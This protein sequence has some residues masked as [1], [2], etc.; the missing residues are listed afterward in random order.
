MCAHNLGF[1]ILYFLVEIRRISSM[2]TVEAIKTLV[3]AFALSRLDH[4]NSLLSGRPRYLLG[5]LQK[6]QKSAVKSA[7]K[8]GKGDHVQPLQQAFQ[9]LPVQARTDYTQPVNCLSQLLSDSF[10][11]Y[12]SDLLSVYTP[13]RKLRSSADTR[14]LRIP[15]LE[16]KHSTNA[17]SPTVLLSNGIRSVL[18]SVTFSPLMSSKLL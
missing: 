1:M 12:F 7:F 2:L 16:Q 15:V 18:R 14:M 9:W 13:S 4:C 8:A 3:C 6:V 11:A 17:V 5:R 10:P